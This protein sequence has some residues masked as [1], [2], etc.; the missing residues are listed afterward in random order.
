MKLEEQAEQEEDYINMFPTHV[1]SN[2]HTIITHPTPNIELDLAA[3]VNT[4]SCMGTVQVDTV[5]Q[6]SP[7]NGSYR[8]EEDREHLYK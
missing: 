7:L 6:I 5:L 3:R 2:N 8:G 1:S 4:A